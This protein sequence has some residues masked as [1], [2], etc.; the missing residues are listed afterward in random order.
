MTLRSLLVFLLCHALTAFGA[1]DTAT[2]TVTVSGL[3]PNQGQ[4]EVT[5]YDNKKSYL[6]KGLVTGR[7]K[8]MDKDTVDVV[9]TDL[10]IGTYAASVYCDLDNDGEMD[11]GV[12]RIPSEPVGFSNNAKGKF[13]PAKWKKTR[14]EFTEDR[15]IT[16]QLVNAID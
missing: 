8:V 13:G 15:N 1:D 2:L 5:L 10:A 7:E 14:F 3:T 6:K 4:V 9:F 16:V 11:T 12:F